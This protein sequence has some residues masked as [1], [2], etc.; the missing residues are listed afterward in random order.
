MISAKMTTFLFKKNADW[1][2]HASLLHSGINHSIKK[3]DKHSSQGTLT[4][5]AGSVQFTTSLR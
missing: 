1:D 3:T 5:G 2:K 4:E